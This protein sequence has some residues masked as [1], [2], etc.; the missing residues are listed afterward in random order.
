M[1]IL[2]FQLSSFQTVATIFTLNLIN[3]NI[4]DVKVDAF[5]PKLAS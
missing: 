5:S 1:M 2:Y 3:S 4:C